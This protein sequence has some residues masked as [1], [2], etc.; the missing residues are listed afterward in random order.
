MG[1]ISYRVEQRKFMFFK[2]LVLGKGGVDDVGLQPADSSD[3]AV[4]VAM[5]H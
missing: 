3:S 5:A 4:S 2:W 1:G